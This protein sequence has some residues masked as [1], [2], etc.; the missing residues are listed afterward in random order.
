MLKKA[1]GSGYI[2]A[3]HPKAPRKEKKNP[4]MRTELINSHQQMHQNKFCH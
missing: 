2:L 4:K 1:R 3:G